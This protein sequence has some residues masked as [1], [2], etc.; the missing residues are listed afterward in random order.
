MHKKFPLNQ[1]GRN[2]HF[3]EIFPQRQQNLLFAFKIFE[4]AVKDKILKNVIN[5]C[6]R[7]SI[8]MRDSQY[9]R[10]QLPV[11]DEPINTFGTLK[12]LF[13]ISK[14]ELVLIWFQFTN[15]IVYN[16]LL[17]TK[18]QHLDMILFRSNM[19]CSF[20]VLPH[21]ALHVRC[22]NTTYYLVNHRMISYLL[23]SIF[24]LK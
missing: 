10:T 18:M 13:P 19:N 4:Y 24:K 16:F 15:T 17:H 9:P 1:E 2:T 3:W 14:K 7:F 6:E 12:L 11:H 20:M 5:I 8:S 23:N 21:L 22:S